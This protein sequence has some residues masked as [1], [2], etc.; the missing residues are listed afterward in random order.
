MLFK[1][2]V[3]ILGAENG[4]S[5][6]LIGNLMDKVRLPCWIFSDI[7]KYLVSFKRKDVHKGNFFKIYI[8]IK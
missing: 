1:C 2:D 8:I 5:N 3:F 6:S 7:L 4:Q